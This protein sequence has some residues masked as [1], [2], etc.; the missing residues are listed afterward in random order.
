M[1]VSLAIL[2]VQTFLFIHRWV[3]HCA[4]Y[5]TISKGVGWA[6][7]SQHWSVQWNG[8]YSIAV[9][10]K[11]EM[12]GLASLVECDGMETSFDITLIK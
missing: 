10:S 1:L 6:A 7:R 8:H 4:K 5:K 11:C 9:V 2:I 12:R 3:G